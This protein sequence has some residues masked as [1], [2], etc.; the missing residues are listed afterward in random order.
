MKKEKIIQLKSIITSAI[1]ES[2]EVIS[3]NTPAFRKDGVLT[4]YY[5]AFTKHITLSFFPTMETYKV[6]ENELQD[7]THS[8]SAIQ[9]PLDQD[10]PTD[11]IHNIIVDA[12]PHIIAAKQKK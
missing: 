7:Y 12:L 4:F 11:L 10:L 2:I 9:F 3:Y 6:F 1:G 8:K 5:A